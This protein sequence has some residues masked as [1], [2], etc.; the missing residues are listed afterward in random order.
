[1]IAF[2]VH[3]IAG[4]IVEYS[5]GNHLGTILLGIALCIGS[6][7]YLAFRLV[8]QRVESRTYEAFL[9]YN[10]KRNEI[11]AVPRYTFAEDIVDYLHGA[12]AENPALKNLW[13][14]EPLCS[15]APAIP[16]DASNERET[17]KS[18]K[19]VSEAAEYF[20]LRCLSIHLVDYF[21]H[22]KFDKNK[23]QGY[24]RKDIPEVL[25]SNLFLE[26]FSTA[27][28][29]RPAFVGDSLGHEEGIKIVAAYGP[30]GAIYEDFDL[31]LPKGSTVNRTKDNGIEIE[32]DK[33][34]MSLTV[35][36]T[37]SATVLPE[38]F[39]QHYLGINRKDSPDDWSEYK[40]EV[41]IQVTMKWAAFLSG[42]GW[43]YYRW[44]DSFLCDLEERMCRQ[45]FIKRIDWE[46]AFTV[47]Q[48]LERSS[49]HQKE[50]AAIKKTKPPG[51]RENSKPL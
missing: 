42:A 8:G 16:E 36:F 9:V 29:N 1:M 32:T 33:L 30:N 43:E 41:L 14:K 47:L 15:T 48:S 27:M 17:L 34:K 39:K 51:T 6:V 28:E 19:F 23:L 10:I 24:C 35:E 2:G 21:S 45:A 26:M 49:I 7:A 40:I 12:F 18:V 25:L 3:L 46:S 5:I 38:G 31:V 20:V 11:I 44:V 22:K 13:D 4:Q 37:R 50:N